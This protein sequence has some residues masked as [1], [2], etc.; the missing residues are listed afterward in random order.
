VNMVNIESI[1]NFVSSYF[2]IKKQDLLGKKRKA[3]FAFPRQIAMYL[4][5]DMINESYPQIAAA[6]LVTIRQFSMRTI[7]SRRKLNKT[8][9]LRT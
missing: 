4:C 3:Q 8:K 6:S 1:Q 5:R 9:K 7:K 2:N